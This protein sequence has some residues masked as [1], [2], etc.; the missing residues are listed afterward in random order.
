[1]EALPGT[2]KTGDRRYNSRR[3]RGRGEG[4]RRVRSPAASATARSSLQTLSPALGTLLSEKFA[5]KKYRDY[6]TETITGV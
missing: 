6:S 5:K 2:L 4:R 1:M 3:L